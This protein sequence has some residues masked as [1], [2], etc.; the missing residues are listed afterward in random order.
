MTLFF[1]NDKKDSETALSVTLNGETRE[2]S[3]NENKICFDVE[4]GKKCSVL[5][6]YAKENT[7]EVKNPFLRAL[8]FLLYCLIFPIISIIVFFD[9]NLGGI[10]ANKFFYGANPFK[11]KKSF[12]FTACESV[13]IQH[14]SPKYNSVSKTFSAPG[15]KISGTE[16]ENEA[17]FFEYDKRSF[18][19]DF[20]AYHYPAYIFLF[21]ISAV[22]IAFMKVCLL[23]QLSPFNITGTI[24][25]SL[26][27]AAMIALAVFLCLSF[28]STHKLFRELDRNLIKSK[29]DA[30]YL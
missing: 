12:E 10:K 24:L 2:I 1:Q 28:I 8:S 25:I 4:N 22:L 7:R 9:D 15:I 21:I 18:K 19:R 23:R 27:M 17:F 13:T 14:I 30:R 26:C 6:E 11:I 5:I 29:P 20:L 3:A 16:A